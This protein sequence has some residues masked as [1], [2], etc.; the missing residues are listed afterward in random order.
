MPL[1]SFTFT[2]NKQHRGCL[3]WELVS[4]SLSLSESFCSTS[5][6]FSTFFRPPLFP[7]SS[8]FYPDIQT[9][10]FCTGFSF[11]LFS[12]FYLFFWP[13]H[14]R[15]FSFLFTFFLLLDDF[16]VNRLL[17]FPVNILFLHP[18]RH[19]QSAVCCAADWSANSEFFPRARIQFLLSSWSPPLPLSWTE[20]HGCVI[21][22]SLSS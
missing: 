16:P 1:L 13:C 6:P 11:F 14:T 17:L 22:V 19:Q 12:P 20:S 18:V 21:P 5:P 3:L 15:L 10:F 8:C 4:L 7:L 2:Q 9:F